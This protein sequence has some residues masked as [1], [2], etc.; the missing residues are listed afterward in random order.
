MTKQNF[1]T[2]VDTGYCQSCE[3]LHNYL[4]HFTDVLIDGIINSP[5]KDR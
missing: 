2:N 1:K 3:E 5:A 4:R